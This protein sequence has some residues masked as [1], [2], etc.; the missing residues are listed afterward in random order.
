MSWQNPTAYCNLSRRQRQ[1]TPLAF[2]QFL[3]DKVRSRTGAELVDVLWAAPD[4]VYRQ[5]PGV[6]VWTEREDALTYSG[7][8][9]VICHPPCGPWGKF[10]ARC[11][12]DPAHGLRAMEFVHLY[13]GVV[14]QPAGSLLFRDHSRGGR[15]ETHNQ[16]DYGFPSVKPTTLYWTVP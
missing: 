7:P 4:T 12:Q 10:R 16:G 3:V 5:I 2:A 14:E 6:R 15:L 13:G 8:G 9:P 11:L 1:A